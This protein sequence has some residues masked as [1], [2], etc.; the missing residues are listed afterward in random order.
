MSE[1]VTRLINRHM[2]RS[3]DYFECFRSKFALDVL[4]GIGPSVWPDRDSWCPEP[5]GIEDVLVPAKTLLTMKNLPFFVIYRSYTGPELIRLTRGPNRDKG[6]NMPLVKACLRWIDRNSMKLYNNN[7]PEYWSPEKAQERIKGDGG[8]YA[9]DSAPTI[10]CFDF[11]FYFDDGKESGWRRRM[12]LD[13]WST[14]QAEGSGWRMDRRSDKDAVLPEKERQK[15][16]NGFLYNPGTRVYA[17]QRTELACFQYA[18]LSAVAPFQY[19]SVR[20]L[21]FMLYAV[22]HLQNRLRCKFNEATFETLTMLLR[23]KSLE[24]VQR[25]LKV[26]LINRGFIDEATSFVPAAE[27]WQPNAGLVEAALNDNAQLI[28]RNS[29]SWT[30]NQVQD[31]NKERK[32]KFQ[33]MAE[34]NNL[35]ALVSAG[36]TQAYQYQVFEDREIFRRFCNKKPTCRD[37]DIKA[38]HAECIREGVDLKYLNPEA[39][40]IEHERV[41]GAGNKTMEMA[42]AEQLMQMRQLY[43][44]PAQREILRDVTEAITDDPARAEQL[45]PEEPQ[46]SGSVHD[47]EVVFGTL[48]ALVPVTPKAGLNAI[49]VAAT[50]V[51]Q[52]G[53]RVNLIKQSGGVGTPQDLMGLQMAVQYA[54]FYIEELQKDKQQQ[55]NARKLSDAIGK[56]LNE[57]RAFGQRQQEQMQ[58]R[59]QQNGG[60]G[61]SPEAQEK[62]AETKATADQKRKQMSQAAAQRTAQADIKFQQQLRHDEQAHKAEL[63]KLDLEA[64]GNIRRGR[65]NSFEEE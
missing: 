42:I 28:D 12:I 52:I 56:L 61:L 20:S 46:V 62:I 3:L 47:T 45:V 13:S 23:V 10:D 2:K 60:G 1:K 34:I 38:F 7:W 4:H 41:M 29:A 43:D 18:D 9:A 32:T 51:K 53:N 63:A 25:T 11:Y 36:L 58:K 17:K 39:W 22:C 37:P 35:T 14:P 24:D 30:Q 57:M 49:E 50:M 64:A 19:H 27:R 21:G 65:L 59:A 40:E 54:G 31:Q 44:P 6:W 48:M 55:P 15:L 5:M 16:E 8:L 26:N 33:V